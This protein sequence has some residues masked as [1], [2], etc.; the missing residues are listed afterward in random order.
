MNN[1]ARNGYVYLP[2]FRAW[3]KHL[4][5]GRV[6]LFGWK[7]RIRILSEFLPEERDLLL[8]RRK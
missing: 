5:G 7:E 8:G 6:R 2:S 1:P 4:G 3:G